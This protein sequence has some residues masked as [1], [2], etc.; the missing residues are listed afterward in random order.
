MNRTI[1]ASRLTL[2]LLGQAMI[3]LFQQQTQ[4]E[5]SHQ[6]TVHGNGKGFSKRSGYDKKGTYM[7]KWLLSHPTRSLSGIYI[8]QAREIA[9]FH[10][11]Q[12]VA[13]DLF[14][15]SI[16]PTTLPYPGTVTSVPVLPQPMPATVAAM[17]QGREQPKPC[18]L[19]VPADQYV[20]TLQSLDPFQYGATTNQEWAL[21]NR[22][23]L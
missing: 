5:K 7:A 3:L 10:N 4:D 9:M 15:P 14:A 18:K 11:K 6:H 1:F 21:H 13:L 8:Q 20:A 23:S 12:L 19:S 22:A 17:M 2:A 16:K